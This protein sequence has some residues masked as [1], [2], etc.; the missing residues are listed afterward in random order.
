[1]FYSSLCQ[2]QGIGADF[3]LPRVF[4]FRGTLHI[5]RAF[6]SLPPGEA[7]DGTPLWDKEWQ[8][9]VTS[10]SRDFRVIKNYLLVLKGQV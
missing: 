4:Y 6:P 1:M 10:R 2:P 3:G 8:P 7:P 9:E 5:W